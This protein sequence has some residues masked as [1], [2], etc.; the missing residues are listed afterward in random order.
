MFRQ[1]PATTEEQAY[2]RHYDIG[3]NTVL[4]FLQVGLHRELGSTTALRSRAKRADGLDSKF[5]TQ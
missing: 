5:L 1:A 3:R 4:K 2:C